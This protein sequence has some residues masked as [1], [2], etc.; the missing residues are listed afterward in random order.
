MNRIL[1]HL[2]AFS[3]VPVVLLAQEQPVVMQKTLL[4]KLNMPTIYILL[5]CSMLIVWLTVDG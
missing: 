5:V 3:A 4:Q 1:A 2:I